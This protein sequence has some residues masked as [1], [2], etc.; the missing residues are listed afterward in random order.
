[1]LTRDLTHSYVVLV[2]AASTTVNIFHALTT[3]N[4]RKAAKVPYPNAYATHEEAEKSVE[5]LAF[6]SAQRAHQNFIDF[7][8]HFL[9]TLGISGLAFPRVAAGL[10]ASWIVGRL[11]YGYGY[12]RPGLEYSKNGKGRLIGAWSTAPLLGL[13]GMAMYTAVQAVL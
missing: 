10:G 13:T 12:A 8:A 7:Y 1:M 6:N 3:G 4:R 11:M 5:K 2:A 9:V